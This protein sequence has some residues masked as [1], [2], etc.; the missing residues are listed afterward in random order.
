MFIVL[1]WYMFTFLFSVCF[2][3]LAWDVEFLVSLGVIDE[4]CSYRLLEET[5]GRFVRLKR[6]EDLMLLSKVQLCQWNDFSPQGSSASNNMII[7]FNFFSFDHQNCSSRLCCNRTKE[8]GSQHQYSFCQLCSYVTILQQK[9]CFGRNKIAGLAENSICKN[10]LSYY[11]VNQHLIFIDVQFSVFQN[12]NVQFTNSEGWYDDI[13]YV[14]CEVKFCHKACTEVQTFKCLC[15][16]SVW[17]LIQINEWDWFMDLYQI[18][19]RMW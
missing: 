5:S 14:Y 18:L 13:L 9:V 6:E 11:D 3:H 7:E 16:S 12:Q 1:W 19:I 8:R 17:A 15:M 4:F 2:S 10:H